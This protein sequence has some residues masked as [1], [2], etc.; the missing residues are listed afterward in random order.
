[1]LYF[2][3]KFVA[4]RRIHVG[5]GGVLI[6]YPTYRKRPDPARLVTAMVQF[7]LQTDR[8]K[9]RLTPADDGLVVKR[10]RL[11]MTQT[12]HW[13]APERD[14]DEQSD[15]LIDAV[16]EYVTGDDDD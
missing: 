15:D 1:M 6:V 10:W 12:Q 9:F 7:H 13:N 16:L 4:S 8:G 3:D 5:Y 14:D 2:W 11:V